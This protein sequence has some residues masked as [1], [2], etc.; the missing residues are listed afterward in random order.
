[1]PRNNKLKPV[2]LPMK[3]MYKEKPKTAFVNNLDAIKVELMDCPTTSQLLAYLPQFI[4]ATWAENYNTDD[5]MP[6]DKKVE[7]IRDAFNGK[8]LPTA[9]ETI[10]LVFR[11]SGISIQEVTHI[12]RHRMASFS[13]DCSGDKWWS[14]KDALV[15]SSIQYSN[16]MF[17]RYKELV[18]QAKKLYCDMIDTN[19]ISIMDARYILPRCLSTFYYMR[20]SFKDAIAFIK[21]RIDR[22]IQPETDNVIAYQMYIAIVQKM[23]LAYGLVDFDSPSQFYIK[24]AR[25]GKATNLYF[26][27]SNSDKF[28]WNEEDFIY[29][30]Y[31][32]EMNGTKGAGNYFA[33]M[34]YFLKYKC[35]MAEMRAET[36]VNML[37]EGK[38]IDEIGA[39]ISVQAE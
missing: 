15:P 38:N 4:T 37:K 32:S 34:L 25:T 7:V 10:N 36:V 16:E 21:Q 31:R 2:K 6:I 23:P 27:E 28:E 26:P 22:Q 9:L 30:C 5:K 18:R 24:M 19:Q 35:A 11:I 8:A 33:E 14:M 13:A 29:K 1:M 3:L 12:L 39:G 20:M 17:D